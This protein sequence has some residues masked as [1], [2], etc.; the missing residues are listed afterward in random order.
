[1]N[2][3]G[4]D[5][6]V[7]DKHEFVYDILSHPLDDE[8][9]RRRSPFR[10]LQQVEIP[11]FSIGV[12]GKAALHL[13]SNLYGYEHVSGPKRLLIAHPSGFGAAQQYYFDEQFHRD[14]LLPWYDH[15]LKDVEN[16]VM[17]HPAARFYVNGED[18]Y[19]S[20]ESWPPPDARPTDL[21]L[22]GR[23]SAAITSLNDG[24][25]TE[26]GPDTDQHSTSWS[27]PDPHWVAGVTVFDERG[28]PDR[29]AR[30]NTFTT[31]PMDRAHPS[32]LRL[33]ERPRPRTSANRA[34]ER[35]EWPERPERSDP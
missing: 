2:C 13:R 6:R 21:Y 24:S 10:E 32:T 35:P 7:G 34:T 17:K 3:R 4:I 18:T 33:H 19:R 20:A 27:Y 1:M 30:V 26:T 15:H 14:E 12:W 11:V 31:Q 5:F 8:W 28:V 25:L 9:H 23:H 29:V 16:G 22:T